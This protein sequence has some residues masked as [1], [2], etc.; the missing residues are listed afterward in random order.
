MAEK[1]AIFAAGC[2]W[3]PEDAFRRMPGVKDAISGYTGGDTVNPPYQQ[4]CNGQTGAKGD[5]GDKGDTGEK[6]TPG[7]SGPVGPAGPSGAQGEPGDHGYTTLVRV[8]DEAA[9]LNCTHGGKLIHVGRDSD[10]DGLL[11]STEVESGNFVCNGQTGTQGP[12]GIAGPKGDTGEKG[13][14]GDPGPK[15]DTGDG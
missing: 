5:K 13:T 12:Q 9:G 1:E 14:T 15:G 7:D 2:F 6:G 4:V 10:R 3:G 11:S 8:V